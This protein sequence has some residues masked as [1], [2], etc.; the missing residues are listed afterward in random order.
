MVAV[1]FSSVVPRLKREECKRTKHD[2]NFSDWKI[3]IGP[4]DWD[5]YSRGK[6]D[7]ARYRI[8]NLP[9]KLSP[10]VYE[11]GIAV[12]RIGVG[13]MVYKLDPDRIVVVYLGKADN[14]RTRLQQ[15]GRTGAHL[16]NNCLTSD[17]DDSNPACTQKGKGFF[18]EIFSQGYPIIYR[19]A[20]MQS[21]EDAKKT[22]SRL[23]NV[24]DYAWNTSNN[25]TRRQDDIIKKINKVASS[26]TTISNMDKLLQPFTRKR[27]GIRI[28]SS[29][30]PSPDGKLH[31]ID[32][33]SYNFVSRVF[34]FGRSN[35]RLVQDVPSVIQDNTTRFCGVVLGDGSICTRPPAERRMRCVEHKGMRING[36][37]SKRRMKSENNLDI[38]L[39]V[40]S[41]PRLLQDVPGVIQDNTTRFCGVV[42][43]DGSI[44][45]RP[46]AERRMRCVEHK[47]MR[48]NGS[49]SQRRMKSENNQD[50][51]LN[52][53]SNPRLLQ[54]VPGVIQ[55]NTT[56]FCG[57]VLGDGS[58]CTRPPAERRMRCFEHKG[59]RINGSTSQRRMKSENNQDIELNVPSNPRLLQDVPGVIQ[60]N[61]KRF[62]GVVLG[63]GSICT[64]P[65]AERRM[66][67]VEHKGM[68]INGST[69]QRR[70]KSENNQDI[71]LNV[72][73]N[74]RL[75]QDVPGVIQDK[76]TRF[77]GVVLGDGS[78]C[79]RPPAERRVRC[80]EH[81]GMRING[82]N[83]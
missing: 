64:R 25:G 75:V 59:M 44:C 8:H 46:P 76:A 73:S 24:F 35:P 71:E 11:L 54:D 53:P 9:E 42:L 50:I 36:S 63:D 78:I 14:V 19:W 22:E 80:V 62:C 81:K 60:D 65:P 21:K 37:T 57:V 31:E 61:T 49:T 32:R 39:N 66:R 48:I 79:T 7:S 56:R 28:K 20:P 23:L 1:G 4:S 40:P 10:G 74:L 13:R 69:S 82:F 68:R 12:S 77:C 18:E 67:C 45:T 27:V 33:G 47:G 83:F 3:L 2:S 52:V 15:Y 72:P 6:E 55:D 30:M 26:P 41:N 38:E 29:S 51:E 16:S 34:K 70:M 58:I 17:P 5:D 43:G